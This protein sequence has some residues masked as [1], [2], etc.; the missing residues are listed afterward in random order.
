MLRMILS[1]FGV[2]L[3]YPEFRR[4]WT[5]NA[6]A[7]AASWALIVTRGWLIYRQSGSSFYV[8]LATFAA[9]GPML[10]VPPVIGV[11]ADRMDRRDRKSTRL[12]SSH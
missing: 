8:G 3:Q 2:A 11:L 5:A 12:N 1:R 7:Q 10:I 4:L 9:M 6:T